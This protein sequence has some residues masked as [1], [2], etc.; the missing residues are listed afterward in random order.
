MNCVHYVVDWAERV[1]FVNDTLGKRR[2]VVCIFII[3][4]MFAESYMERTVGLTC[5]YFVAC[6]TLKLVNSFF[7]YLLGCGVFCDFRIFSKL[8]LVM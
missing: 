3:V 4:I 8:F 5:V 2:Y 1:A 6:E 7:L